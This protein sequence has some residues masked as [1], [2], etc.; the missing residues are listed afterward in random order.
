[1]KIYVPIET[2]SFSLQRVTSE[3]VTSF[4]NVALCKIQAES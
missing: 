1:M 3:S 2:H 4:V